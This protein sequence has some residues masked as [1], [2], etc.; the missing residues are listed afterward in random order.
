MFV[1][2]QFI[3]SLSGILCKFTTA[4][5]FLVEGAFWHKVSVF[6][7]LIR[8]GKAEILLSNI[9]VIHRQN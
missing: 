2:D 9:S 6:P 1:L 5:G 3:E 8:F 4:Q 7:F